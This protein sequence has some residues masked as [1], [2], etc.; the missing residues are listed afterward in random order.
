[1][2]HILADKDLT[3]GLADSDLEKAFGILERFRVVVVDV[4]LPGPCSTISA[5]PLLESWPLQSTAGILSMLTHDSNAVRRLHFR[6]T[7]RT[8]YRPLVKA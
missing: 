7:S 1:M 2:A 8:G 4:T 5:A 6:G 3:N